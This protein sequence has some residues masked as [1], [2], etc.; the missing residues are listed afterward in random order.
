M[1]SMQ[2]SLEYGCQLMIC[3]GSRKIKV[4]LLELVGRRTLR[5]YLLP[6]GSSTLKCAKHTLFLR[7]SLLCFKTGQIRYTEVPFIGIYSDE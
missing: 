3:F 5:C 4:K 1:R 6:V 7:V 2:Y